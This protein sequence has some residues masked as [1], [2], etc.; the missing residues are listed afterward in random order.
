MNLRGAKPINDKRTRNYIESLHCTPDLYNESAHSQFIDSFFEWI[1]SSKLNDLRGLEEFTNR[2]IISG[3]I[4]AFDHFYLRHFSRRFRFFRGEF[5]YHSA[6]LKKSIDWRW[7]DDR[8]VAENDAVI[9][10]IPFSDWGCQREIYDILE[11]CESKRVPVL[12]DFAYYP[13]TKNIDFDLR[14]FNC[15]ETLAFSISKAFYGAEFLRVGMRLERVDR[16]DAIDIFNSVDMINRL[17]I[18]IASQLIEQYSV[19]YNWQKYGAVYNDVCENLSLQTTDCIM[20]GAGGDE[21]KEYNRGSAVNRV[22]V[23]EAIGE[24]TNDRS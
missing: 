13:C 3:T 23:S 14:K 1:N 17:G 24:Y 6:C 15:I 19:D 21:Y 12:L 10:S 5:M 4:Q 20:F 2:K 18:S 7:L 11:Q 9:V 22:C 16:D 8:T